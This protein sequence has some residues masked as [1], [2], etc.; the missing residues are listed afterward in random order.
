MVDEFLEELGEVLETADAAD[1]GH[2][3]EQ[4]QR[5]TDTALAAIRDKMNE[6]EE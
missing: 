2:I 1:A 3:L 4:V 5:M 6:R